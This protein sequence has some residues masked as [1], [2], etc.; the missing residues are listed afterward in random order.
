MI[1]IIYSEDTPE[2]LFSDGTSLK[3]RSFLSG[4]LTKAVKIGNAGIFKCI[5][6]YLT[7]LG[8][9]HLFEIPQSEYI[10]TFISPEWFAKGWNHMVEEVCHQTSDLKKIQIIER[11]FTTRLAASNEKPNKYDA[12]AKYIH[13]QKG[14][15]KMDDLIR[16]FSI[17]SRTLD[18]NFFTIVGLPPKS[19]ANLI[20][21]ELAYQ[22]LMFRQQLSIQDVVYL[23]GYYD[24]SHLSREFASYADISPAELKS[25]SNKILFP[26]ILTPE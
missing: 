21:L 13:M 11:F 16:N 10:N 2:F 22:A 6:A 23:L 15:I 8:A 20:R 25:N 4:L 24:Q 18:R 9:Y 19:Y 7:P 3:T 1:N 14:H 12:I 17:T 26:K 5:M